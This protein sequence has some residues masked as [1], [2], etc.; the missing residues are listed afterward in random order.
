M[1]LIMNNPILSKGLNN[2]D[3]EVLRT[4]FGFN[5]LSDDKSNFVNL[6]LK[7]I[8]NYNS[9]FII[10]TALVT[11]YF[12]SRN[13]FYVQLF[14]ALTCFVLI[15]RSIYLL[16]IINSNQKTLTKNSIVIRDGNLITV[17]SRELVPQD[18]IYLKSGDITPAD[19]TII[20]S[21]AIE[22]ED[23]ILIN[24]NLSVNPED[25]N[26]GFG[27]ISGQGY[28]QVNKTGKDITDYTISKDKNS[29]INYGFYI[30]LSSVIVIFALVI[31]FNWIPKSIEFYFLIATLIITI[32]YFVRELSK[33]LRLTKLIKNAR[34]NHIKV[35]S[36]ESID[37]VNKINLLC[38]DKTGLITTNNPTITKVIV[39]NQKLY[40][41]LLKIPQTNNYT[42]IDNLV[43]E[44][45]NNFSSI[46]SVLNTGEYIE[47]IPFDPNTRLS[48]HKF[49]NGTLYFGSPKKVMSKLIMDELTKLEILSKIELEDLTSP[50]SIAIGW[51]DSYDYS[52]SYLGTYLF[53]DP[54]K[55]DINQLIT[56][57]KL[58]GITTKI[59]SAD[60]LTSNTQVAVNS[61]IAISKEFCINSID[62]N[63]DN[64]EVLKE[65][66]KFYTVF[67]NTTATQKSVIINALRTSYNIGYIG[68]GQN[69]ITSINNVDLSIIKQNGTPLAKQKAD[70]IIKE[71]GFENFV[72]FILKSKN[73]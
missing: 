25:V 11:L 27:I 36:S 21:D 54:I 64:I 56:D 33:N 46:R 1:V 39:E 8:F 50:K 61:G 60:S 15:I 66:V 40:S 42:T 29:I 28:A 14:L 55:E 53:N 32:A 19:V 37:K 26:Y 38:L 30:I 49:Q 58:K 72:T 68:D 63:F 5:D 7:S 51:V 20:D 6:F 41:Y 48:G 18:I 17:D 44:Y 16:T 2:S 22:V 70:V 31:R 35:N 65:Q 52:R 23:Q 57:L 34:L 9:I 67:A 4:Q 62:L 71:N 43:I 12:G 73:K 59:I 47:Y 13:V 10:L 69:D 45:A 24:N 3:V